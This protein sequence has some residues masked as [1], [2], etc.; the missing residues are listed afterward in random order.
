MAITIYDLNS[1]HHKPEIE[2]LTLEEMKN[3]QGGYYRRRRPNR[4]IN[5]EDVAKMLGEIDSQIDY[6]RVE[7]ESITASLSREMNR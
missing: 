3:I 7:L 5:T 6:L 4:S 2:E 1:S